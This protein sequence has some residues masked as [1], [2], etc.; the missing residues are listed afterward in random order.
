MYC[1]VWSYLV[2]PECLDAFRVAYGP[3]GDWE[4]LFRR[5]PNYIHTDLLSDKDNSAQFMTLDFWT[6]S[7]AREAF[8]ENFSTEFEALDKHC[9]EFTNQEVHV[10][11]YEVLNGAEAATSHHGG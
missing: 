7:E 11:D 1:Y 6:S 10:G 9:G 2:R 8:R 3:E 5:D 4:R